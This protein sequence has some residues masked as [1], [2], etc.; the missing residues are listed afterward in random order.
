[1][2]HPHGTREYLT[3]ERGRMTLVASGESWRLD[4]GDLVVFCGDQR[5]SDRNDGRNKAIA[6]SVVALAPISR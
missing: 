5:H 4:P 1:M 3:C 6:Y 2:P